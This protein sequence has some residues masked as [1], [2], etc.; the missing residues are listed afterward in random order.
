MRTLRSAAFNSGLEHEP[1]PRALPFF[2][3]GE[4]ESS[5][6]LLPLI[7]VESNACFGLMPPLQ[8]SRDLSLSRFCPKPQSGCDIR[9]HQTAKLQVSRQ[10]PGWYLAGGPGIRQ[11]SILEIRFPLLADGG[12]FSDRAAF[13]L[14]DSERTFRMSLGQWRFLHAEWAAQRVESLLSESSSESPQS[15]EVTT[16]LPN[17]SPF[18]SS[19]DTEEEEQKS[20][21]A[22][23]APHTA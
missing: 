10:L 6:T 20:T 21:S 13:A 15:L 18:R 4:W 11:G 5:K 9:S 16:D 1:S 14:L 3:D 22:P 12:P 23:P 19:S 7:L 2:N 8:V 17:V